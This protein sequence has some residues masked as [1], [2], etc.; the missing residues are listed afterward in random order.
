VL[1][2]D[3]DLPEAEPVSEEAPFSAEPD[4]ARW[5]FYT[6][7]TTAEPK[8]ARHT[9]AALFEAANGMIAAAEMGAADR[10]AMVAPITHIGGIACLCISL[11]TGM[12][13]LFVETFDPQRTPMWLREEGVTLPGIGTP[14]FLAYL[15]AQRAHPE[16]APLFPKARAFLSGGAPK[17][18]ALHY[19]LKGEMGT[20]GIV[21]GYGLT[22]A[23]ILTFGSI[24][25]SD[26]ELANSEGRPCPGVELVL[27]DDEVRV[28]APQVMLGYVD[29][30][31]DADAFDVGGYFR[32]GDLGRLDERMNL[33]I[34][35]RVKDIII[36]NMEN[37]SAKEL[38]DVLFTHPK[39]ADVAVVGVPDERVGERA[40][41]VVVPASPEPPTLTELCQYL[42]SE[43]LS[44][45][46][47][48]E[49]LE[50]I[51]VLPRNAMGKVLKA[52]LRRSLTR[53][54]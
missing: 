40:C 19:E 39:V 4:Q 3:G 25:D 11:L 20:V 21:S 8:G 35:G 9:D 16:L 50:L 18:V 44:T 49:Q 27:V 6:S 42:Q 36:R 53:P 37:I 32:T 30:A 41:A 23:P 38:E 12:Q 46:K 45:R 10:F 24:H 29:S 54:T 7:G 14:F 48:P 43:G 52:E 13:L 17:P 26:E 28:K 33:T 34:T 22:E 15:A 5:Y 47:M 31:L 51:D 2:V 1:V